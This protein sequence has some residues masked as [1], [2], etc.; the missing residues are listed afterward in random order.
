MPPVAE[1]HYHYDEEMRESLPTA[2]SPAQ[3]LVQAAAYRIDLDPSKLKTLLQTMKEEMVTERWQLNFMDFP[4]WR[5]MGFPIGL[6]ASIRALMKEEEL[7]ESENTRNS[8]SKSIQSQDDPSEY[9][10]VLVASKAA[11]QD[12]VQDSEEHSDRNIPEPESL[13]RRISDITM[14]ERFSFQKMGGI[15]K[16][17]PPSSKPSMDPIFSPIFSPNNLK[18]HLEYKNKEFS[19]SANSLLTD[20]PPVAAHRRGS[21][22]TAGTR[23]RSPARHNRNE[24]TDAE[25]KRR[26]SIEMPLRPSRRPTITSLGDLASG[27][28]DPSEVESLAMESV[29]RSNKKASQHDDDDDDDSD[30]DDESDCESMTFE[31]LTKAQANKNEEK[32]DNEKST[33]TIVAE[34]LGHEDD[35]SWYPFHQGEHAKTEIHTHKEWLVEDSSFK[36]VRRYSV[37]I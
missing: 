2:P 25:H 11:L 28:D 16:S 22:Q 7:E 36:L 3:A 19:A 9:S 4:C 26:T 34:N 27:I 23:V 29:T 37:G 13:K 6:I 8:K 15:L 21:S 10:S 24:D 31:S 32:C 17:P 12:I 35:T 14:S 33:Q 18:A 20:M 5:E 1:I 30:S